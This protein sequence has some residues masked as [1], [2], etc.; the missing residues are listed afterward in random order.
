MIGDVHTMNENK[1]GEGFMS[2]KSILIVLVDTGR[3]IKKVGE[4]K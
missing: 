3:F 4:R 2:L 1:K